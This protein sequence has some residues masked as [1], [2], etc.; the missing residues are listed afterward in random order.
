MRV[1]GGDQQHRFVASAH[2]LQD[3]VMTTITGTPAL[4]MAENSFAARRRQLQRHP[5]CAICLE[6]G[7]TVPATAVRRVKSDELTSLCQTCIGWLA[8]ADRYPPTHALPGRLGCG[9]DGA[10]LDPVHPADRAPCN[11]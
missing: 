9:V 5:L 6:G 10:S 3:A 1:G 2:H 7:G 8:M 4:P 11:H